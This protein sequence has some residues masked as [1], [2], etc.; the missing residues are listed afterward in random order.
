[1]I[2]TKIKPTKEEVES[3]KSGD[4]TLSEVVENA[5][6]PQP[7]RYLHKTKENLLKAKKRYARY[8]YGEILNEHKYH[9]H[10]AKMLAHR[11]MQMRQEM[12]KMFKQKET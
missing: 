4:K 2:L 1:M 9:N 8:I 5:F 10:K 7:I 11:R 12:S 3:V 6:S